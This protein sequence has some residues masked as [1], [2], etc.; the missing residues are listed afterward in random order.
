MKA[1]VI[2]HGDHG[3]D[4]FAEYLGLPFK[5]SSSMALD[6]FMFDRL[7]EH[8]EAAALVPYAT[9]QEAHADRHNHRDFWF[10]EISAF[11]HDDKARM[12]KAILKEHDI[13]VGMRCLIEYEASKHLFDAVYWVDAQHRKPLEPISSFSIDFIPHEM[14]WIDNNGS[15][16]EL[17]EVAQNT[18]VTL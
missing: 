6:L 11:T 15:L 14:E 9:K 8:L 7:N 10:N 2:G 3:K 13:Y 4:Q 18:A 12:A 17:R 5:S 1:L 16:E